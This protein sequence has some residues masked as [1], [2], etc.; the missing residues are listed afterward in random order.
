MNVNKTKFF[1]KDLLHFP[2]VT[3]YKNLYD[4]T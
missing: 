3:N 4:N 2:C 1:V